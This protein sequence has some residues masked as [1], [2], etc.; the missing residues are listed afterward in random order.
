MATIDDLPLARSRASTLVM[1]RA[2]TVKQLMTFLM[3]LVGQFDQNQEQRRRDHRATALPN[4]AAS[5]PPSTESTWK[6]EPP[7]SQPFRVE[8]PE[9]MDVED[10]SFDDAHEPATPNPRKRRYEYSAQHD[11][12]PLDRDA[13]RRRVEYDVVTPISSEEPAFFVDDV[14]ERPRMQAPRLEAVMKQQ[15]EAYQELLILLFRDEAAVL[16]QL[17]EVDWK[18]QDEAVFSFSRKIQVSTRGVLDL[19]VLWWVLTEAV[20]VLMRMISDVG[21]YITRQLRHVHLHPGRVRRRVGSQGVGQNGVG[22]ARIGD[23]SHGGP[24]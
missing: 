6:L 5:E 2:D 3:V 15:A 19:C 8:S 20:P 12:P 1:A 4:N 13:I 17:R 7:R 21:H 18:D 10:E 11:D 14:G 9:R 22:C 24:H 23:Q 16:S